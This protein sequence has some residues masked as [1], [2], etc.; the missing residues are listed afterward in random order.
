MPLPG[1]AEGI[2]AP[3]KKQPDHHKPY[4][5]FLSQ[6]DD[7]QALGMVLGMMFRGLCLPCVDDS[8]LPYKL[9]KLQLRGRWKAK[10]P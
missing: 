2:L 1:T 4:L 3:E 10:E 7:A 6:D 8:T 5:G 9:F